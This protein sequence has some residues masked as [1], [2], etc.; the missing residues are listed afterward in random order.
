MTKATER[1]TD[2]GRR[3]AHD[4]VRDGLLIVV[5]AALYAVWFANLDAYTLIGTLIIFVPIT[6]FVVV[7]VHFEL[8][9]PRGSSVVAAFATWGLSAF[10]AVVALWAV[11]A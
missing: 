10:A 3:P 1:E 5:T 6:A 11:G 8:Q 9:R 4:I 2:P 7:P